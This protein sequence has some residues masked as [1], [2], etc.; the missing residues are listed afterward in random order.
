[1]VIFTSVSTE[2]APDRAG[3]TGKIVFR[4]AKEESPGRK[5]NQ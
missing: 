5:R 3:T 1:M 2:F 4:S